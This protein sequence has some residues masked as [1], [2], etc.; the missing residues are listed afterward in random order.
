[1]II[2]VF[3]RDLLN[4]AFPF[5][6]DLE[7]LESQ[8]IVPMMEHIAK[9]TTSE[10]GKVYWSKELQRILRHYQP[11][12]ERCYIVLNQKHLPASKSAGNVCHGCLDD[13]AEVEGTRTG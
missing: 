7:A 9:I 5:R 12:C 2:R 6:S 11:T 1:M 13:E 10:R 8:F 3:E 4:R